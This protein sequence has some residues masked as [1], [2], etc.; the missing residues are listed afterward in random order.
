LRIV[1]IALPD[2]IAVPKEAV[3]QGPRGPFV[4]L[5]GANDAAEVRPVRLG[6]QVGAAWVISEGLKAGDRVVA[7]GVIRVRAGEKVRPVKFDPQ[8]AATQTSSSQ[9]GARP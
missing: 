2:A 1:G 6:Q 5:V 4:Y 8:A 7:D 9:P 3:S